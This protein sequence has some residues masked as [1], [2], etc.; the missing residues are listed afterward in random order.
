[1]RAASATDGAEVVAAGAMLFRVTFRVCKD[2]RSCTSDLRVL[3]GDGI[4]SADVAGRCA[5]VRRLSG[6]RL[7][8]TSGEFASASPMCGAMRSK[9]WSRWSRVAPYWRAT[10]AISI[11]VAGTV[12]PERLHH[13]PTDRNWHR[14]RQAADYDIARNR[15]RAGRR[16]RP[17]RKR[18][19]RRVTVQL[20]RLHRRRYGGW[21]ARVGQC[22]RG[23]RSYRSGHRA[24][25]GCLRSH[26]RH[27]L[28]GRLQ[29]PYANCKS[30]L[31]KSSPT[32]SNGSRASA[33]V[34]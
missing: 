3:D 5:T 14:G 29:R 21:H 18:R 11:S 33:A 20:H 12:R 9:C 7:W 1:V 25:T 24:G 8:H 26:H 27:D 31:P 16:V 4:G 30:V 13:Q 17:E 6:F 10:V 28:H 19:P 32:H 2:A 22:F 23:L 15:R 34:A